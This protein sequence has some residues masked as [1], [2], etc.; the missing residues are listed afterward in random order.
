MDG[1]NIFTPPV[2]NFDSDPWLVPTVP[3]K[4]CSLWW[5]YR[6]GSFNSLDSSLEDFPWQPK[7]GGATVHNALIIVVLQG[8]SSKDQHWKSGKKLFHWLINQKSLFVLFWMCFYL[9]TVHVEVLSVHLN[10]YDNDLIVPL[11]A[12]GSVPKL[13]HIQEWVYSSDDL[14]HREKLNPQLTELMT[15]FVLVYVWNTML[16][17]TVELPRE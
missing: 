9:F 1:W 15:W 4:I 12:D 5:T 14:G 10:P 17:P 16:P 2:A 13:P 11:P 8:K 3:Q 6:R 7:V